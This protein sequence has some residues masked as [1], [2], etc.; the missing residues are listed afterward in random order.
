M[1]SSI[2]ETLSEGYFDARFVLELFKL[3]ECLDIVVPTAK[4]LVLTTYLLVVVPH[5]NFQCAKCVEAT[6]GIIFQSK[7]A[8]RSLNFFNRFCSDEWPHRVVNVDFC[9]MEQ[10]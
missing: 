6:S 8:T 3:F 7:T 4:F 5:N 10:L 2:A 9:M 1:R